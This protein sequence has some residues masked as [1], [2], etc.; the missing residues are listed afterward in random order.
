MNMASVEA[1]L[2]AFA[3]ADWQADPFSL[4]AYSYIPV[5]GIVAPMKL[6]EPVADTLFFAGEATAADGD[7]ATVH[8][9]IKSGYR[10]AG[11]VLGLER[12]YAA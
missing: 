7:S 5:G 3:V 1:L 6:A 12:R 11:E 9:A 8:G 4:G 2:S 10:A